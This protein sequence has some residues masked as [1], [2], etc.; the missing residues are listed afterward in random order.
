MDNVSV[1]KRL[2]ELRGSRTIKEVSDATGIGWSTLCMYELGQ[3]RPSD[4]VKII[5]AKY[6][7]MTVQELFYDDDIA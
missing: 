6:Y 2:R 4:E 5:L 7:G 1:G 3:R